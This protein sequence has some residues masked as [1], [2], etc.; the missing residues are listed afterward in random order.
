[1]L[2]RIRALLIAMP[3]WKAY[4]WS[5]SQPQGPGWRPVEGRS[6]EI[7]PISSPPPFCEDCMGA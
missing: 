4:I 1:M 6:T 5:A 3:A 2:A 7:T